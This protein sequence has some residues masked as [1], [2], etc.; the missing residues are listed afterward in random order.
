MKQD[1]TQI[2]ILSRPLRKKLWL[3]STG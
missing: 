2:E 1:K 3:I